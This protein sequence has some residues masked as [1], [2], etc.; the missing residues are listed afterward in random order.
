MNELI[1]RRYIKEALVLDAGAAGTA[2]LDIPN[3]VEDVDIMSVVL[4]EMKKGDPAG[5]RMQQILAFNEMVYNIAIEGGNKNAWQAIAEKMLRYWGYKVDD[6]AGEEASESGVT[7]FYDAQKGSVFYSVKSAFKSSAKTY[8]NATQS[9]SPKIDSILALIIKAP[10]KS[11]LG[12]IGCVCTKDPTNPVI[13]WGEVTAPISRVDVANKINGFLPKDLS[14]RFMA[15]IAT[16]PDNKEANTLIKEIKQFFMSS[17]GFGMKDARLNTSNMT[18]ILGDLS[19]SPIGSLSLVEPEVLFQKT[20]GSGITNGVRAD[21]TE[22]ASQEDRSDF[23]RRMR[24]VAR[25]LSSV[26][27]EDVITTAIGMLTSAKS[28][29]PLEET[30]KQFTPPT[31]AYLREHF[32]IS[33]SRLL[34]KYIR[35][36]LECGEEPGQALQ[37]LMD[38]LFNLRE[39][40]KELTLLEDHINN[41]SKQCPDCINKHLMKCEA[42]SEEAVSLDGDNQYPFISSVPQVIRGWHKAVLDSDVIPPAVPAEMRR[43]RKMIMPHVANKFEV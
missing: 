42:L 19:P 9:S 22:V 28:D 17:E 6:Q 4:E 26:E 24:S 41:P 38:P 5:K 13:K 21:G 30:L 31:Q 16:K 20:I 23:L 37:P 8:V 33:E 32:K 40:V 43:F 7:V 15:A 18:K 35:S 34:K 29:K 12:N 2:S 36:L 1:L 11:I 27:M 25:T 3:G 39:I 14:E 10:D